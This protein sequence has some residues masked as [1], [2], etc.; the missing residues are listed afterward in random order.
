MFGQSRNS[1]VRLANVSEIDRRLRSIEQS[2]GRAGTHV[3]S[4]AVGPADHITETVASA[5][6]SLADRFHG[7][8]IGDDAAK[9]GN[10]AVK[11][12]NDALRRVAKEVEHR[13]LVTLAL[14]LGVGLLVGVA[15]HRR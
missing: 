9:F 11:F 15:Y 13:P 14:A 7:L 6:A 1:H 8:S 2:L 4:R 5:L 3:A 10:E 12:G